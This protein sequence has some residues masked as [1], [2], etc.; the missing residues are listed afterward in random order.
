MVEKEDQGEN[1][2]QNQCFYCNQ[3][4]Q[5]ANTLRRHCRQ[6]HG[7]DRC[8]IC[9]VCGKAFKR[10]T[11]LKVSTVTHTH[12]GDWTI[13]WNTVKYAECVAKKTHSRSGQ[14]HTPTTACLYVVCIPSIP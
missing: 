5:S 1:Q 8:H 3:V 2:K 7:K 9:R 10:A 13:A 4:C 6:A 11:H 14:T 12:T